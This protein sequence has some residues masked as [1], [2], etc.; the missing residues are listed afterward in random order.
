MLCKRPFMKGVIPCPCGQC[1][2]CRVN[3]RRE[4]SNRLLLEKESSAAA[5]FVTLTYR[6]D[7]LKDISSEGWSAVRP[8]VGN[9]VPSDVQKWLKRLRLK[10]ARDL[11]IGSKLRFY[12]VGEYGENRGRPHYHAALFGFPACIHGKTRKHLR[13]C[14]GPCNTINQT[15]GLGSVQLLELN[16]DL[17]QYLAKYVT[18][19][20]TQEN[21][22]TKQKLMGRRPEFARMSLKPGIGADAIRNL[23]TST[24]QR[25]MGK[26]LKNAIDAPAVLLK[27]GSPLPLG[28]YLRRKWREALGRSQDAPKSELGRYCKEMQGLYSAEKERLIKSGLPS[29]FIDP[30]TVFLR[31]IEQKLRN[32]EARQKIFQKKGSL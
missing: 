2:H 11:G 19:K 1:M 27:S 30:R 3:K 21:Q 7:E 10:M 5:C 13:R 17:A 12:L 18:K 9:L 15:W 22:W 16:K 28:K 20:W 24:A 8:V 26:Y 23:V 32:A 29:L 14:C 6:D 4:W 25:R 31:G